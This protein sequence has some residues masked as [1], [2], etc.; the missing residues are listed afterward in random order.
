M[1]YDSRRIAIPRVRSTAV[2]MSHS[3]FKT[4]EAFELGSGRIGKLYSLR[5]LEKAGLG[6]ISR[7]PVSLRMVLESV[8]RNVD[9]KE[10]T[11]GHVR[12][13]AAWKPTAARTEEIPFIVARVLTHD[14]SGIPILADFA[15]M[16]SVARNLG[17]DPAIVRPTVPVDLVVDH[18]HQVDHFGSPQSLRLNMEREFSRNRERY[19][20]LKW[21][22]QAFDTIR[23]IPPGV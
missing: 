13:L 1:R 8:L 5:A 7:V 3:L 15:A 14:L 18:S 12:A 10:I 23:F 2:P 19:Q 22:M 20:F 16:R 4:L 21:G 17:K 9:G 6:A 11:E